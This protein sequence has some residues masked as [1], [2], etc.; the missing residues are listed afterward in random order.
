MQSAKVG[1]S[2][3]QPF[4][5]LQIPSNSLYDLDL[6]YAK[7][8]RPKHTRTGRVVDLLL[9]IHWLAD[10]PSLSHSVLTYPV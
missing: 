8:A 6:R 2:S 5:S 3:L 7:V 10:I 4:R 1:A 9:G